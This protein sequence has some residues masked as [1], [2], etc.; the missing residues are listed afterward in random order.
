MIDPR[1]LISR[2]RGA[3]KNELEVVDTPSPPLIDPDWLM[4]TNA[5]PSAIWAPDIIGGA[6]TWVLGDLVDA[7]KD[8]AVIDWST[9][10]I[11]AVED[12]DVVRVTAGA[13]VLR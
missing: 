10:S 8:G 11:T 1:F 12:G 9:L 3:E 4:S 2:I 6:L 13:K 5:Y 7:A